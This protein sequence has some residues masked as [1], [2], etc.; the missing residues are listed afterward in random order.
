MSA[1]QRVPSGISKMDSLIE[2][3]F[4]TDS[5]ILLVGHPGAGKST[6]AGEFIYNAAVKSGL[7]SVY[8]CFAETKDTFFSNMLRFE[9]DFERLERERRVAVLDLAVTREAGIQ[10]NLNTIMETMSSFKASILV[11]DSFTA[12]SMALKEYIDTR[13]MIHLFYRFLKKTNC[14]S[15]FIV[16]QPWG[17]SNI[18]DRVAEFMADGIIHLESFFDQEG[19]MKRQLSVIKMRGTNH[20]KSTYEYENNKTGFMILDKIKPKK[21]VEE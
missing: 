12:I 6:L 21:K 20:T 17:S 16:D 3:G 15:L 1:I 14:M 2:G 8:A 4:P 9:W 18:G 13:V 19:V 10:T 5:M 11:I 7:K